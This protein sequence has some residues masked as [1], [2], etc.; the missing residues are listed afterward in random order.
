M[1][2]VPFGG[3]YRGI[4]VRR[5]LNSASAASRAISAASNLYNHFQ[6]MP[7]R[8]RTS[9]TPPQ[10]NV[11]RRTS[12][13]AP[14]R[15]SASAAPRTRRSPFRLASSFP[16]RKRFGRRFAKKRFF[17]RRGKPS[18]YNRKK[19]N[20]RPN[21]TGAFSI[22][23]FM[24][25][26]GALPN[27]TFVRLRYRSSSEVHFRGSASNQSSRVFVANCLASF[28]GSAATSVE[29]RE[30]WMYWD[31]FKQF[32]E[33]YLV[34][35]SRT[36]FR[37]QRPMF[38]EALANLGGSSGGTNVRSGTM[39][40]YWYV[41]VFYQRGGENVGH[42]METNGDFNETSYWPNQRSFLSD[43]TVTW[44]KD[45]SNVK[46]K[47]GFTLPCVPQDTIQPSVPPETISDQPS[48]MYRFNV[49]YEG[50]NRPVRLS[51]N[52][53]YKKHFQDNNALKN[54]H[55]LF[56]DSRHTDA[57]VL[58]SS[59]K[60]FLFM[61]GYVAFDA[62]GINAGVVPVDRCFMRTLSVDSY[63]YCALK[64]P[65]IT[66]HGGPVDPLLRAI[67]PIDSRENLV[68]DENLKTLLN[69]NLGSNLD[70]SSP[71]FDLLEEEVLQ[72]VDTFLENAEEEE[73]LDSLD[74][75]D[76]DTSEE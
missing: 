3:G 2:I 14:S 73:E 52:F 53:S 43:P 64:S 51:V 37:V 49:E 21:N 69:I 36:V 9:S 38:P 45:F 58:A 67:R 32:Y 71:E 54:G 23:R 29:N 48:L 22:G 28:W 39:V 34:L 8:P 1:S 42:Y 10:R 30:G 19:K 15:P 47:T 40:G 65:R 63:A 35:G 50:N 6:R 24:S 25:T 60:P 62:S 76:T 72:E 74:S 12:S 33:K 41:R 56:F 17:K 44:I 68:E 55:F 75:L 20:M 57:D 26:G 66:P 31:T 11:R 18:I 13:S 59:F 27:T 7:R 5:L 70:Q 16:R 61:V 4:T 46:F